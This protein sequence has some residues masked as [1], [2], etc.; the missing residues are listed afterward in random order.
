MCLLYDGFF[1]FAV[2]RQNVIQYSDTLYCR[3]L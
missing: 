2:A 3:L 1:S